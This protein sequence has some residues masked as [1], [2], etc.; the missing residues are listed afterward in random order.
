MKESIN[1]VLRF[2]FPE[3]QIIEAVKKYGFVAKKE[4]GG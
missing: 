2:I 1:K 3:Y 4:K